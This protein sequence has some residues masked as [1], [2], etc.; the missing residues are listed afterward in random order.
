MKKLLLIILFLLPCFVESKHELTLK[1]GQALQ[2]FIEAERKDML[3]KY[4][5]M[6]QIFMSTSLSY[7]KFRDSIHSD[8]TACRR[9]IR[10]YAKESI[11]YH[12]L[13]QHLRA[14]Y[15][16]VK[17]HKECCKA[18]QFHEQLR[19]RYQLAFNNPNIVQSVELAP[20]LY[21]VDKHKYKSRAYFNK[22]S[23]D[24]RKID[25]LEDLIHG[26]HGVLKA[27][28]YVYKIE[29]IKVRNYIYHNNIYKF[30][31]RYF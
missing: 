1:N 5:T 8:I 30:E 4:E 25:K 19:R 12:D 29:L 6:V 14:F 27:H 23:A 11:E 10:K 15:E 22:V 7:N 9:F 31:T 18:I 24:L 28:N 20:E 13:L 17:K 2:F 26:D 21:G 3:L 16:Y